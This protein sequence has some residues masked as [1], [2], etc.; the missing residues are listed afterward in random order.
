MQSFIQICRSVPGFVHLGLGDTMQKRNYYRAGWLKF[1]EDADMT[2]V[3]DRLG[4]EKVCKFFKSIGQI[5]KLIICV[6]P[7]LKALSYM[8]HT[9]LDLSPL[10]LAMLLKPVHDQTA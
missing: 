9:A 8:L 1:S 3:I 2:S 6:F 7:R 4:D 5:A 10:A